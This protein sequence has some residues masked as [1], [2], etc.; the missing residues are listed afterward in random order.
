MQESHASLTDENKLV[1]EFKGPIFFSDD[2]TNACW[3][4]IGYIK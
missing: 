3:V 1:D 4:A 2:K